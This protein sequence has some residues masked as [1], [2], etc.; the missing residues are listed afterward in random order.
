M[1][2]VL[3]YLSNELHSMSIGAL[4]A[5]FAWG[6][7]SMVLSPCHLASI[8]L[9][10]GFISRQSN[11]SPSKAFRISFL[12]AIGILITI[13]VIGAITASMGRLMGDIGTWINYVVAAVLFF[14]GL[15][16]LGWVEWPWVG[17]ELKPVK[18]AGN[19]AALTMGLLF[20]MSLGPCTFAYMAPML[21]IVFGVSTVQ[22]AFAMA[23]LMAFALGHCS[24]ILLAGMLTE[25]VQCYL[26]WSERTKVAI[27]IR[28]VSGALVILGGIYLI[29]IA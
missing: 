13:A 11:H 9:V 17:R 20:G 18:G 15:Y 22:P 29:Y 21:G 8:P 23:M 12:F 10:V 25:R 26:N 7:L 4:M 16:L 28:K 27:A 3:S 5:C 19:F 1:E 6:V 14:V 24:V 2:V